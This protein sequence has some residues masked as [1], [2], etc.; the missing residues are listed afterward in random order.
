[1]LSILASNVRQAAWS[2]PGG[3]FIDGF[4]GGH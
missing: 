1:M 4:K 2:F 3:L